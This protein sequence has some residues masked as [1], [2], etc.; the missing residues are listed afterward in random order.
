MA[1]LTSSFGG[2]GAMIN[3]WVTS[4]ILL[5][6]GAVFGNLMGSFPRASHAR[7]KRLFHAV[8]M[9]Q[10]S[11]KTNLFD[12]KLGAEIRKPFA[13]LGSISVSLAVS[14]QDSLRTLELRTKH[15][16]IHSRSE[17]NCKVNPAMPISSHSD[18]LQNAQTKW[19][20][21][22][23]YNLTLSEGY[24]HSIFRNQN[25]TR[26]HMTSHEESAKSLSRAMRPATA[27]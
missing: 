25:I 14:S 15:V 20:H 4:A 1:L 18:C 12:P 17:N 13:R 7:K 3:P 16:G 24:P 2:K 21:H 6:T 9:N 22:S 19:I 26:N 10:I 11:A 8:R 27:S 5:W 23:K